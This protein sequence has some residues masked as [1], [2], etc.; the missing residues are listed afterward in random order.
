MDLKKLYEFALGRIALYI[1]ALPSEEL[2]IRDM[3]PHYV[4]IVNVKDSNYSLGTSVD[5]LDI[6][7]DQWKKYAENKRNTTENAAGYAL[8]ALASIPEE[9]SDI[10]FV[11]IILNF[12]DENRFFLMTADTSSVKEIDAPSWMPSY[13]DISE[14]RH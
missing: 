9:D 2:N 8:W 6:D 1:Q 12:L 13:L 4:P 10:Y 14:I 5:L 11:F 3:P 7:P